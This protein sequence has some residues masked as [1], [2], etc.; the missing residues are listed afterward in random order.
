M[1]DHY[2]LAPN[3]IFSTVQGEGALLGMPMLFVRLAGC[4]INCERCDTD[5]TVAERATAD[6]IARRA[7]E[8]S[9]SA[10]EWAWITGGEPT[11]RDITPLIVALHRAGFR[12]ALATAGTR[13]VPNWPRQS[14]DENLDWLSVSPH[15][16]T[17][18]KQ[19][20]GD[21]L[22]IVPGL[23]GLRLADVEVALAEPDNFSHYFVQPCDGAPETVAECV[24][25]VKAHAGWRMT[26]QAHKVWGLP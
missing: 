25:W 3:A 11:D 5:Y 9:T 19:R 23:N 24:G 10:V 8:L 26:I 15:D 22:K 17:T 16:M 1:N 13:A 18:W 20:K 21:E 4:S 12:V 14:R 7:V 2:A 6:E